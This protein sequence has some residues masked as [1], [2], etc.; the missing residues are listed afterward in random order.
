[1]AKTLQ[2]SNPYDTARLHARLGNTN[3]VFTLLNKAWDE[4]SG[5]MGYL[6]VDDC[7]DPLRDHPRFKALLEKV[8]Y[9][10]VQGRMR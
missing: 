1:M 5:G 8:G 6:L 10:R 4:R 3:E 7:W 2:Q 9:S